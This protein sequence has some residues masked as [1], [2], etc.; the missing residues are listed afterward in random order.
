[1]CSDP[2]QQEGDMWFDP[3]SRCIMYKD[4]FATRYMGLAED[5]LNEVKRA[6]FQ[7][8]DWKVEAEEGWESMLLTARKDE[9]ADRFK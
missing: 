9:S 8:L 1:M 2:P 7:I 4:E 3:E 6:G 5:I